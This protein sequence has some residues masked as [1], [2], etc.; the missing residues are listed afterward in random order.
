M[1]NR[2][3]I[4]R[5]QIDLIGTLINNNMRR[6]ADDFWGSP[7]PSK[8]E[9]TAEIKPVP[10]KTDVKQPLVQT[11]AA[12]EKDEST[13]ENTP[14]EKIED[15]K[16]ELNE[17][18]G[19]TGVKREVNNLINMATIHSLRKQNGLKTVDMSLHM[20]FSGNPG[21]GKTT[22]ARLMSRIYK[23]L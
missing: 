2:D 16:T 6:V 17:L 20:V 9:K 13:D 15:L 12:S 4:I 10:S 21:T 23:S 1:D 22:I 19:L 11:V 3:E 7:V 18:I 8:P 5:T 14:P